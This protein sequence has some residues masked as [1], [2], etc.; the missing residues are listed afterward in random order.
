MKQLTQAQVS[1]VLNQAINKVYEAP[2]P[3][4][5]STNLVPRG[6]NGVSPSAES[7]S[8]E[9][10]SAFGMA[11]IVDRYAKDIPPTGLKAETK[12]AG[13]YPLAASMHYSYLDIVDAVT[14]VGRQL[15]TRRATVERDAILLK[16]DEL[17]LKG[18]AA[19]GF[20]GFANNPNVPVVSVTTGNWQTLGTSTTGDQVVQDVQDIFDAIKTATEG[21]ERPNRVAI[22]SRLY[23]KLKNK[24]I[25]SEG[26]APRVLD[27][28]KDSFPQ[29]SV[30]E[31]SKALE[32]AGVG[33]K[34][35][36]VVYTYDENCLMNVVPLEFTQLPEQWAGLAATVNGLSV[37]G[38]TVF[39]RPLSAA[40]ADVASAE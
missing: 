19:R 9:E 13:L 39:F 15:N 17:A 7:F 34:D 27:Y 23:A 14:V 37:T 25:S 24:R 12:Y 18:D 33:G 1:M 2:L 35:R 29:I 40:Y 31:S 10:I 5:E 30:W 11:Q 6:T 26:N 21:R 36:V 20:T 38:G 22:P 32:G 4:L 8:W 3:V 16:Q 28:L